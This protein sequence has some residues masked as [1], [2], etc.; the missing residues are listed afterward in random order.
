MT[1]LLQTGH[2]LFY[3]RRN[4]GYKCSGG[5]IMKTT[6]GIIG[7]GAVGSY[8]LWGLTDKADTEVFVIAQGERKQRYEK[9]GFVINGN[10]YHPEIKTPAE[11]HGCDVLIVSVKYNALR[12]SLADIRAAA[13]K[14]TIVMSLM[15]GVDSEEIISEVIPYEQIMPAVIL[16]S[17]ERIGNEVRF[18]PENAR[19]ICFGEADP[20][21]SKER[22]VYMENLFGG[23]GLKYMVARNALADIWAKFRLN[24]SRNLPQAVFGAGVGAYY[25]S[26]HAA[27]L[28][29]TLADEVTAI[30]EAKGIDFS[31]ANPKIF[32]GNRSADRARYSTLQDLDAGRHTEVDMLAGTA[33]RLGKELGV[34]V[35]C[36]EF[37]YHMIKVIEEKNDGKFNFE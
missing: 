1:G 13:D 32:I 8:I 27:Y 26:E 15:N 33:V 28:M 36:C 21:R 14:H 37:I 22:V 4:N 25:H 16:I 18:D 6:V 20:S 12:D 35:P 34:P 30:A 9:D 3:T 5:F 11:A 24:V 31:Q 19:G 7:T 10:V 23:T 17:S 29:N 2:F